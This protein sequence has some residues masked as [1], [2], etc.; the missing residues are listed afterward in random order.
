MGTALGGTLQG[1]YGVIPLLLP[2]VQ[3]FAATDVLSIRALSS[4]CVVYTPILQLY[5]TS[6]LNNTHT[7][8]PV[9]APARK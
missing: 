2:T 8:A 5:I 7:H 9:P 4:L 1:S 3:P 6:D